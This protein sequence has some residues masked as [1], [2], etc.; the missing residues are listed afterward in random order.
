M[1]GHNCRSNIEI[2]MG[3]NCRLPLREEGFSGHGT[4]PLREEGWSGHGSL[5]LR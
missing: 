4:L 5:P 1:L 2:T 3:S